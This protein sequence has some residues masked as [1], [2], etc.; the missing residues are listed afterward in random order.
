M[1]SMPLPTFGGHKSFSST[2]PAAVGCTLGSEVEGAGAVAVAVAV[3]KEG[4]AAHLGHVHDHFDFDKSSRSFSGIGGDDLRG[5]G[6]QLG[7]NS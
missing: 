7:A 3:A 2:V 6:G 4:M 5:A 1:T